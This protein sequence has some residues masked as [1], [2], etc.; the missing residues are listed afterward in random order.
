M[1][2]KELEAIKRRCVGDVRN[3][4]EMHDDTV[5]LVA[6]VEKLRGLMQNLCEIADRCAKAIDDEAEWAYQGHE[7]VDKEIRGA[8]GEE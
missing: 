7:F 6:E 2:R 8:L 5:A 4:G 3:R 1:T